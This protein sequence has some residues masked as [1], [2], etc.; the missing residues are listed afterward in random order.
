M[1]QLANAHLIAAAP[2]LLEACKA[3]IG[4]FAPDTEHVAIATLLAKA[5]AKAETE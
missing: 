1:G 3:A 2:E 4:T 5:I